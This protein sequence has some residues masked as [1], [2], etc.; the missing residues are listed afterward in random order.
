MRPPDLPGSSDKRFVAELR[1]GEQV[2]TD[3]LLRRCDLR[4][5]KNG[6]RCLAL[7]FSDKSGRVSGR[8]WDNAE[9]AGADTAYSSS[10]G[11][12]VIRRRWDEGE[13]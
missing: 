12:K 10:L 9:A 3:F 7:E 11:R 2:D 6:E 1:V 8:M 13:D 5:R 4:T